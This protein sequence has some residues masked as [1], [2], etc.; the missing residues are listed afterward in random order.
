MNQ[1]KLARQTSP[2]CAAVPTTLANGCDSVT[3]IELDPVA[4]A[5]LGHKDKT[6]SGKPKE[7]PVTV[8]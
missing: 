3:T 6:L 4:K 7:E 1:P 5:W 2:E 8:G